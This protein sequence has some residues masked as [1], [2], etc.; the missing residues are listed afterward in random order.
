[1][2]GDLPND[3]GT[4]EEK[5]SEIAV[6]TKPALPPDWVFFLEQINL[7]RWLFFP[8][9]ID[10][11]QKYTNNVKNITLLDNNFLSFFILLTQVVV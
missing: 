10:R 2:S 4:L 3:F 5:K 8:L 11:T 1:M 6:I 7:R 9:I